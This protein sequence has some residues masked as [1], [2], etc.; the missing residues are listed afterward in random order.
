M[1]RLQAAA[2]RPGHA[3]LFVGPAGSRQAGGGPG[4]RRRAAVPQRRLRRVPRLPAGAGR[5]APRR[6]RGG[7]RRRGHLQGA[8]R[9]RSSGWPRC[10]PLEGARKV[11]ILDEFHLIQPDVPPRLL[12]TIEEPEASTVFVIL[13]DDVPNELVTIASRCVRIDFSPLPEHVLEDVLA[14][15]GRG[16]RRR[17]RPRPRPPLATSTAPACWPST[18]ACSARRDAFHRLPQRLDGTRRRGGQ[19]R[20][21]AARPHRCG[22]RALKQRQAEE[23]GGARPSGRAARR[24][25]LGPRAARRAPQ[26]GAA[27]PSHRRAEGRPPGPGQRRTGTSWRTAPPMT[28]PAPSARWRPSTRRSRRSTAT[29]TSALLLAAA[30]GCRCPPA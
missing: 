18:T 12:K 13:A 9:Q 23:I 19:G 26:A 14:G 1:A 11:L 20:R 7:A 10:M 22:G 2:S 28:P 30:A 16:C 4:L 3:Y 27:P 5:R 24:A 8:G 6:P 17:P 21:R 15:L 25:G 29:P